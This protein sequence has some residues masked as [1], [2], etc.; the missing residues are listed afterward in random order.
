M[1]ECAT[2]PMKERDIDEDERCRERLEVFV[3]SDR[4]VAPLRF[5]LPPT[6]FWPVRRFMSSL[7]NKRRAPWSVLARFEAKPDEKKNF[8]R[9]MVARERDLTESEMAV[10]GKQQAVLDGLL[11][12]SAKRMESR[13]LAQARED[14][15]DAGLP[16]SLPPLAIEGEIIGGVEDADAEGRTPLKARL[17]LS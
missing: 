10:V 1:W 17:G 16:D 11:D 9:V 4:E 12:G 5:D 15:P 13:L 8:S 7:R 6:S 14:M 2:C 3:Q